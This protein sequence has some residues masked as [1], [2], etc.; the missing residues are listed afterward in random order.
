MPTNISNCLLPGR[1]RTDASLGVLD[2][3]E[4]FGETSGGIRTYLLQKALYVATRPSLRHV[5]LV[6]GAADAITDSDGV[7]MYRLQGPR[8]PRQKPYRFMLATRSIGRIVRHEK[9]DIIEVGSPFM[10]PWIVR[11]AT[12]DLNIPM[13]CFYHSNVPGMFAPRVGRDGLV[14]RAAHRAAWQYMR[15]LDQIFPTTIVSSDCAARDLARE[16]ITRI[17]RVPL[18]VDLER[19]HPRNRAL[20]NE[21]RALF[22]LPT[23]PL[24]GFVGRF[25]HEKELAVVLDAWPTVER[26][27]GARL[28]LVGAGPMERALRSHPY[29]SRVF[30]VPFQG[31]RELLARLLASFDLYISPGRIETFGLSSIEAMAS[32]TPVLGADEGGVTEQI[33]N[34]QAGGVFQA[35]VAASLAEE[36]IALFGSDLATMGRLGREYA[37]REHD[38][39]AVFDRL[40][41]V[42][43]QILAS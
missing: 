38:W 3:T 30:F 23:N 18:G 7:R 25:A 21:T 29:A 1:L 39:N 35:G 12:R 16:G 43:R 5:L 40:F 13:I 2:V 28:V 36:A 15:R 34:S 24:A 4:W 27:T 11:R 6:P 31:S 20:S 33:V 9:P 14:Q 17:A 26:R 32:G 8:I 42:Y 19:F 41:E 37:A 22:N 10:V